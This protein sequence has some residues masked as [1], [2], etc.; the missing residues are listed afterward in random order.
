MPPGFTAAFAERLNRYT[1]L[2]VKEAE[3]NERIVRGSVYVAP[4]GYNMYLEGKNG[5][6]KVKLRK[7]TSEDKYVPSVDV[8]FSSIAQTFGENSL[9][10]V[11]T[12]MGSDGTLGLQ[13]I[14]ESGGVT[15]AESEETSVVFGMPREAIKSGYV[16]MVLSIDRV[17]EEINKW[18]I[19]L[20]QKKIKAG[21]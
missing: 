3:H 20:D 10:V 11:L 15:I 18:G 14:R 16:K 13:M 1:Y 17:P 4:G 21:G 19:E 7:R 5:E 8:L 9:G 6:Y 2:K 12:G